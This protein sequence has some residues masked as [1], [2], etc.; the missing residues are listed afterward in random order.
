MNRALLRNPVAIGILALLAVI[1][2]AATFAVVPETSQAVVLRLQKPVRT[3]NEY[4][5]GEV[6]GRTGAGVIARIPFFDR[7]V[8]VDKRVLDV[9]QD[10]RVGGERDGHGRSPFLVRP[11]PSR[12]ERRS[13]RLRS[14]PTREPHDCRKTRRAR[15]GP[16][17][18]RSGD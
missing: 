15:P 17:Q 5:P 7:I 1:L 4:R 3:V 9:E 8:W 16:P 13:G 2:A 10:D 6:F 12:Q 11:G 14:A 18:D